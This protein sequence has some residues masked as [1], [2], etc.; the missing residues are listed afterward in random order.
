M[1]PGDGAGAFAVTIEN[2]TA[3]FGY[4][5]TAAGAKS[6]TTTRSPS[7]VRRACER[8]DVRYEFPHGLGLEPRIDEDSGDIYGP[9]GTKVHLTDHHRQADRARRSLTLDD[10][11]KRR[12]STTRRRR[13]LDGD[14]H[15]RRRRLVSRRARRS[16]TASRTPAT[17]STSSAR[18][19][20]GRRTSASS[21][22]RATSRSRRSK[23]CRSKRARTTT[24]ASRRSISCFR[25]RAARNASSRSAATRAD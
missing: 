6:R 19:T 15:D 20:I 8:I 12:R 10:G 18:S 9:A 3:P 11:T 1:S 21:G 24:T 14:A 7:C 16:S 17:P 23:K 5:V 4:S 22:R 13:S 25:R 2:V